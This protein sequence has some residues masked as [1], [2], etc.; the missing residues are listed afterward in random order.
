MAKKRDRE[1]ERERERKRDAQKENT[2][3]R[4][5]ERERERERER[6]REEHQR[7]ELC[8]RDGETRARII[9]N[10]AH[11]ISESD[12]AAHATARGQVP[13]AEWRCPP[14]WSAEGDGA[15][16]TRS[17]RREGGRAGGIAAVEGTGG[18]VGEKEVARPVWR[19]MTYLRN[20]V[21]VGRRNIVRASVGP[22]D[23]LRA[24]RPFH[25]PVDFR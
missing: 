7:H 8:E 17:R 24:P 11:G 23:S 14:E 3:R 4:K 21:Y 22:S 9:T 2:Q 20:Q 10:T 1:T 19:G 13:D 16:N 12:S 18:G 5:G 6:K 15:S 25:A